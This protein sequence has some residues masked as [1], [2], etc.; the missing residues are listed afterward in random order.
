MPCT[1]GNQGCGQH[2][3]VPPLPCHVLLYQHTQV[4]PCACLPHA[5]HTRIQP[6][7]AFCCLVDVLKNRILA[8]CWHETQHTAPI[9]QPESWS[10][11]PALRKE[12]PTRTERWDLRFPFPT[13]CPDPEST[14]PP[15][16]HVKHS[17]IPDTN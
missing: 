5:P 14:S 1:W 9:I 7:P 15:L 10:Q 8:S 4:P 3:A 16:P 2:W 6:T 17:K 13:S 12:Q 11:S